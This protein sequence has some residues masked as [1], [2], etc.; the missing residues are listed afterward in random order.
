MKTTITRTSITRIISTIKNKIFI[1]TR[2]G[3][4][5]WN[6]NVSDAHKARRVELANEDHCGG[7]CGFTPLSYKKLTICK[8]AW[9][10]KK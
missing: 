9:M 5:R 1:K 3:L 10:S 4:G 7:L 6:N 2:T 8:E